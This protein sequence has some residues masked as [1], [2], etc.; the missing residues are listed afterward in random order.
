ME[1]PKEPRDSSEIKRL[2]RL[3]Q[4]EEIA[5]RFGEHYA[6]KAV[7]RSA[8]PSRPRPAR[9]RR[10]LKPPRSRACVHSPPPPQPTYPSTAR[11]CALQRKW[12]ADKE[13]IAP[14]PPPPSP[15]GAATA[16]AAGPSVPPETVAATGRGASAALALGA[17]PKKQLQE[18]VSR[19]RG[20]RAGSGRAC[21]LPGGVWTATRS[22]SSR[23][24]SL[25]SC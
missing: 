7:R 13:A 23:G 6:K 4:F 17:S 25:A 1:Q 12:A 5:E 24:V 16:A 15:L 2:A 21:S 10:S 3:G 19:E 14:T 20:A 9:C 18:Q 22:C 8:R 11:S